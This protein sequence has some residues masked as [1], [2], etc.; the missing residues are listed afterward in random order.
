VITHLKSWSTRRPGIRIATTYLKRF[1][2]LKDKVV[3]QVKRFAWWKPAI[4]ARV[5]SS[6]MAIIYIAKHLRAALTRSAVHSPDSSSVAMMCAIQRRRSRAGKHFTILE[7]NGAAVLKPPA[8]TTI[9]IHSGA[10]TRLCIGNGNWCLPSR[11]NRVR[12]PPDLRRLQSGRLVAV[13]RMALRYPDATELMCTLSFI[14]KLMATGRNETA[15]A[16]LA[17]VHLPPERFPIEG[18]YAVYRERI[19]AEPGS[20]RTRLGHSGAAQL[21]LGCGDCSQIAKSW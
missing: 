8:S 14:P 17:L 3:P 2:E 13:S 20:P 1:P 19:Q 7:L 15:R 16:D 9:A 21:V 6:A 11:C 18:G 10:P 5:P 4:I 12:A